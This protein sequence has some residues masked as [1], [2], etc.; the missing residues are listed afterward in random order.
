MA[1]LHARLLAF[2]VAAPL[3]Y[4]AG[5]AASERRALA[6]VPHYDVGFGIGPSKRFLGDKADGADDS[7]FGGMAMLN[8]DV[9]L[10]PLVKVGGYFGFE[11][12]PPPTGDVKEMFP[13]G[14]RVTVAAPLASERYALSFFAGFGYTVVYTHSYD[15]PIPLQNSQ[16][17]LVSTPGQL[18]GVSGSFFEIPL[19][20]RVAY[21]LRK[22]WDVFAE[23]RG[24][25][26][27]GF[28]AT[29]YNFDDDGGRPGHTL[30]GKGV[31]TL[32]DNDGEDVFGLALLFGVQWDR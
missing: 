8:A 17:T 5:S 18:S 15:T 11:L 30:V 22:N 4:L 26:G 31:G 3:V 12:S 7:A 16:G 1:S 6:D 27:F 21:H 9:A 32:T 28:G 23:L 29:L 2:A 20:A 24:S 25:I 14:A 13:F 19:G 10:A